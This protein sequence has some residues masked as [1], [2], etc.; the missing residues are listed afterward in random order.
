MSNKYL[1][2]IPYLEDSDFN[3]DN[4]LKSY[5]GQGL[6]VVVMA[7]GAFCGYCT[8]AKPAFKKFA[9]ENK[10]VRAV[11]LQIDGGPTEKKAAKRISALDSSYRGV[12]TYLGFDKNGKYVGTHQGGRDAKSLSSFATKLK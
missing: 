4:S 10:N 7:Q 11:T 12:P 2:E 8:K 9:E 6:P 1:I 5:V 3:N